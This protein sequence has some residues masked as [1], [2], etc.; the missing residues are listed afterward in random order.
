[1]TGKS[2][3]Y[4]STFVAIL[5]IVVYLFIIESQK[6]ERISL[7]V[8][9]ATAELK[10]DSYVVSSNRFLPSGWRG[11]FDESSV[12]VY[13]SS[14]SGNFRL[15]LGIHSD[16]VSISFMGMGI[17]ERDSVIVSFGSGG[18]ES[19]VVPSV[20][21]GTPYVD[22]LLSKFCIYDSILLSSASGVCL[23][24]MDVSSV[25]SLIDVSSVSVGGSV[26]EYARMEAIRLESCIESHR[27]SVISL[28]EQRL[29][30]ERSEQVERDRLARIERERRELA[31]KQRE[32]D[33]EFRKAI[34]EEERRRREVL[35]LE[36]ERERLERERLVQVERKRVEQIE[37]DRIAEL[38]RELNDL[39]KSGVSLG[40][41][42]YDNWGKA[43]S[44]ANSVSVFLL[45]C[46][47]E[48]LASLSELERL[49]ED[50]MLY[51][52]HQ[53]EV[54]TIDGVEKVGY[55]E[56]DGFYS[57]IQLVYKGKVM[58]ALRVKSSYIEKRRLALPADCPVVVGS[59]W[60][61]SDRERWIDQIEAEQY[62]LERKKKLRNSSSL[63][64][65]SRSSRGKSPVYR[66]RK[67]VGTLGMS[68]K[69]D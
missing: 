47:S 10:R 51:R 48:N 58:G 36:R 37:R 30:R 9:S 31:S 39:L 69:V 54:F 59:D 27:A 42:T 56:A 33:L 53:I 43:H 57:N 1:M 49:N 29:E 38:Q 61:E 2:F 19:I 35:A 6:E 68:G 16:T 66:S 7:A 67:K 65:S 18:E 11:S 24:E 14:S 32:R 44:L 55:E 20:N 45:D 28:R 15:T 50:L 41:V 5:L 64:S 26:E 12:V 62:R 13:R 46:S 23:G 40:K 60:K 52:G 21:I 25:S 22:L 34:L 63:K 17:S 3:F 8:E 4:I